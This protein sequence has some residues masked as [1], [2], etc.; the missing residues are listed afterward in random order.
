M[1]EK[2]SISLGTVQQKKKNYIEIKWL[3]E[4]QPI[5]YQ[6]K[7]SC[8]CTAPKYDE[9]TKTLKVTYTPGAVPKHKQAEGQ[10][11]SRQQVKIWEKEQEEY[12][13]AIDISAIVKKKI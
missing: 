12:T 11:F 5:I 9:K 6:M 13:T 10:Y 7:S 2:T 1:W 4:E 8:G 3:G